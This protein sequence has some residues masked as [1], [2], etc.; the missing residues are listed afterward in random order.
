MRVLLLTVVFIVILVVFLATPTGGQAQGFAP[1]GERLAQQWCVSCHMTGPGNRGRDTALPFPVIAERPATTAGSL[2]AFL[3][4]PHP[5][6]P[7]LSLS[8]NEMDDLAAYILSL[9]G[10]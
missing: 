1:N 10:G 4:A 2:K 5:P 7:D 9:R 8:R 3:S 6:M